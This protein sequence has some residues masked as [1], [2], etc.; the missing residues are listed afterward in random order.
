MLTD[1][2]IDENWLAGVEA[3]NPIFPNIDQRHWA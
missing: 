3:Q 2:R 1:T